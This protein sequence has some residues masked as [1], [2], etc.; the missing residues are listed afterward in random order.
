MP[1]AARKAT[2]KS[3]AKKTAANKTARSLVPVPATV[4][5]EP[6]ETGNFPFPDDGPQDDV[7]Q[8]ALPAFDDVLIDGA[9]LEA[10]E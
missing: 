8:S 6:E 2:K 9:D 5:G 7:D 3:A 4:E 10:E 1:T